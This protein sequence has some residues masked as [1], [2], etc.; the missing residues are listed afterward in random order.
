VTGLRRRA[1]HRGGT[2]AA[3]STSSTAQDSLTDEQQPEEEL[4]L[5]A[6][7]YFDLKVL[8]PPH[9]QRL[10]RSRPAGFGVV[11]GRCLPELKED[12][13]TVQTHNRER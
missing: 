2:A 8:A 6:K 13:E 12:E 4:Y 11:A 5:L 10:K 7:S 3:V 1:V 9:S